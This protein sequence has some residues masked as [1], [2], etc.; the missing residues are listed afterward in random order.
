MLLSNARCGIE[1]RKCGGDHQSRENEQWTPSPPEAPRRELRLARF[2]GAARAGLA[3]DIEKLVSDRWREK[4]RLHPA[5]AQM[6]GVY[7]KQLP[8]PETRLT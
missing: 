2:A 1:H 4:R 6:R 8:V 5:P 7:R 3:L